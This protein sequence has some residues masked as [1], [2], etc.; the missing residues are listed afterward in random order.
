MSNNYSTAAENL[1]VEATSAISTLLAPFASITK[2][3][4]LEQ[5]KN[6]A[7]P[8][9]VSVI[10]SVADTQ[11]AANPDYTLGDAT[12]DPATISHTLFTQ[13][14]GIGYDELNLGA[15]LAWLYSLNGQKIAAKLSDAISALLT[16]TNFGAAIVHPK[17][18]RTVIPSLM[19]V[20]KQLTK[21][22]DIL[23]IDDTD[24][25]HPRHTL[26][27]SDV[28][29]I[30][31]THSPLIMA[32]VEPLFDENQD[33]WFDLDLVG[34]NVELTH[35][36]FVRQGDV[37]SWLTSEAFNLKSGYS[38]EAETVLEEAALALSN[39]QFSKDD[40]LSL[41]QRLRA[42]L[43]DTDP[44]WMRWRFVGEKKGWSL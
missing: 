2:A 14:F 8:R 37:R 19:K 16:T 27:I 23:W 31:V 17:W 4:P 21:S 30:A 6:P 13:P 15:R 34:N 7:L 20:I 18:Q 41:E 3:F 29:L 36:K 42:V 22:P 1:A 25:E 32:S 40:A 44:F 12:I 38:I 9:V 39:E 11:T 28:Q 26:M 5:G 35:R 10:Q 33:A 24:P 43:S